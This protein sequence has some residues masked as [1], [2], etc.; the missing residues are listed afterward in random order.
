M[1]LLALAGLAWS[2]RADTAPPAYAVSGWSA[3]DGD[4]FA[5]AVH[6]GA[7]DEVDLDWFYS[8]RNGGVVQGYDDPDL[9]AAARA[10]GVAVFATLSNWSIAQNGFA[11]GVATAILRSRSKLNRHAANVVALCD[12]LGYDGI[13]LDWESLKAKERDRFSEFV[14]A[15]AAG[16]HAHGK[17]LAI[18]VHPKTS[19]PGGWPGAKAEDWLRLGAA[20]DEF[21]V[22]TYDYSGP[23]SPPGP[24]APPDWMDAV[25]TF[26]ES[27]VPSE[28]VMMG[29]PFYGYDWSGGTAVG[30]DWAG[31]Q[32]LIAAYAPSE[33]RDPS[34][35]ETLIY[36]DA[37][38]IVHTVFFQDQQSIAVKL[39]VLTERHPLIRGAAIWVLEREDP[40]FWGVT[41]GLLRP[42]DSC[43]QTPAAKQG[44]L[45]Q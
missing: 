8:K 19:E 25:L 31:A 24:I 5:R 38:G 20:V 33:S 16:L 10:A 32:A 9:V 45:T 4:S 41:D 36:T 40:G 30:L 6:C 21:K 2:P 39:R 37:T 42:G 13:D 23:W 15:L 26:A 3:G 18:A 22:M 35:E 7:I 28:K 1:V 12:R 29:L 27:Q 43:P 17:R 34:G 14:E 11:P 44:A